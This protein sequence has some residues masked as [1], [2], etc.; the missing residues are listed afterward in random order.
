[1]D[2]Q[3]VLDSLMNLAGTLLLPGRRGVGWD[4]HSASTR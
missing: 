2:E 3:G 1:M 4:E